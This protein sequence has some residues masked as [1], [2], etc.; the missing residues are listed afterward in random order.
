MD[1]LGSTTR[2]GK[3]D[4]PILGAPVSAEIQTMRGSQLNEQ[5]GIDF[6]GKGNS[7][8]QNADI[9][10]LG[11]VREGVEDVWLDKDKPGGSWKLRRLEMWDL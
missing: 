2:I 8:Y 9:E 5:P 7:N 6:P 3:Q 11:Y 1:A 4:N 10:E